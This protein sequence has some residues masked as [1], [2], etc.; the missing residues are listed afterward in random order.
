MEELIVRFYEAFNNCDA[1]TMAQCYHPNVQF[2][3]PAFGQLNPSEACAMWQMLCESQK[4]QGLKVEVSGI[5]V[6]AKSGTAHWKAQYT[7]SRTGRSVHN[8]IDA[9]F[10]FQDG[11][12]IQH[13]DEFNLHQWA[14]QA[15]G[16][17]GWLLGGT[18][19][20]QRK[21]QQQ[22]RSMLRKYMTKNNLL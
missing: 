9:Q 10:Q 16:F 6:D 15:L 5:Q 18:S 3:D 19:F 13:V 20:F 4:G 7:F 22:T 8:S 11:L 21:L 17:K 14:K 12:I 1:K 2:T